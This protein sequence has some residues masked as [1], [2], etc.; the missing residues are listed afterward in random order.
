MEIKNFVKIYDNVLPLNVLTNL[1][2]FANKSE[3]LESKI[4]GGD[5]YKS[6]TD[7]NVGRTY[8]V[9]RSKL[10]NTLSCVD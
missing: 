7:F 1:I 4:G 5:Q 3:F 8:T 6:D 10:Q 9:P 2:I